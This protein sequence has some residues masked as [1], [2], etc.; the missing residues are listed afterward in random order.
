MATERTRIPGVG[1]EGAPVNQ[2][3]ILACSVVFYYDFFLT[4]PQEFK[5]LWPCK[6]KPVNMLVIALRYITAFGYI[7]TLVLSLAAVDEKT[8]SVTNHILRGS[9]PLQTS[10]FSSRLGK[11]PGIIGVICQ[12]ITSTFLIIRLYAIYD[13]KR[14]ALYVMVPFA[15]L[16]VLLSSFAIAT[17]ITLS[18]T[19]FDSFENPPITSSC[20]VDTNWEIMPNLIFV[21]S[22]SA[23]IVFDTLIFILAISKMGRLRE[24]NKICRSHSSIVSILLRDGSLLY[25]ILA[26]SNITN[27][28]FFVDEF[29]LLGSF[30][31]IPYIGILFVVSSGTNSEM[32]HALSAILV[33]RMI[34]NLREAG[35]EIYEGTEEW[36]SRLECIS[37]RDPIAFRVGGR[38]EVEDELGIDSFNEL[39]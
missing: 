4:L 36:R 21:L 3:Y 18:E 22:Y 12:G 29:L 34:F 14:W 24:T 27:F 6:L 10:A 38:R 23:T 9:N 39:S 8:W 20:F 37:V 31:R 26:I 35:T 1:A 11:V 19:V 2:Y 15:S 5:Y 28:A 33:S 17:S 30:P 32:T 7:P 13:K 16:S 25:A